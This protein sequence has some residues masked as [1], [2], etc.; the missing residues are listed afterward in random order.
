MPKPAFICFKIDQIQ[1]IT[2]Y[3]KICL[4]LYVY[5]VTRAS[6]IQGMYHGADGW[7]GGLAV[8]TLVSATSVLL[9]TQPEFIVTY[10]V[11][12]KSGFV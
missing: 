2:R 8:W 12:P 5:N 7:S 11:W 3:C 4:C 6:H 9:L 10:V 1:Y